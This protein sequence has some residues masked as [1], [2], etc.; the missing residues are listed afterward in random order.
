MN[1]S[2]FAHRNQPL[3]FLGVTLLMGFGVYSYFT[4]PAQEDPSITIRQAVITTRFPG[5]SAERVERLITKRLEEAVR[6]VPELEKVTST[7]MPGVSIIHAEVY[8][9]YFALDQ[10]WDDLRKKVEAARDDLPAGTGEPEIND[11][12]GDVAVVTVAFMAKDSPFSD[13]YDRAK[14]IR[15]ALYGVTGT[16]RV[17]VLGNR[18]ERIYVETSSA[19]LA[20]LGLSPEAIGHA[21]SLRNTLR[22]GGSLDT[23]RREF[24]V[25][26]SGN[27]QSLEEIG[28]TLVPVP[29]SSELIPVRDLAN[30]TRGYVDPPQR[31]AYLNGRPAIVFAVSMLEG[32]RVLDYC[33]AVLAKLEA[34]EQTLPVGYELEVIA[35]QSEQVANAVYGVTINVGQTLAI[36]LAVVLLFLGTRT[37]L[38]VGAIVPAVMLISLAIMGFFGIPLERMSLATLVIA[39][40][41]LVDNGIVIAEDFKRRL[42]EGQSRDDALREGGRQLALPLLS[43]TATT[44]LVFLPLMLAPHVSGEYTRS[45]SLVI[46]ISLLTSW[47]VAMLVTPVLR[48]RYLAEPNREG[49]VSPK[50]ELSNRIFALLNR[51]YESVLR[52]VL[53]HKTLF[54]GAM[55]A[56][57]AAAVVGM[58]FVPKKFFPD[59]DR[60]QV[61]IYVDLPAETSARATDQ[62]IREMTQSISD[63]ERFPYVEDVAGYAG[64]GG[65]RFVLS[66]TPS[67]P[68]PNQGFL[69]ATVESRDDIKRAI[70]ELHA[71]LI[72]EFPEAFSRVK[73]M[74][75]GPSDSRVIE[76]EVV[77]PDPDVL[78]SAAEDVKSMLKT[79]PKTV[80]VRSDWENRIAKFRVEVDEQRAQRAGLTSTDVASAL[81]RFFSGQVISEYREN[82]DAFPIV[83]R[84]VSG[85]RQN[86]Q[87]LRGAM[88]YSGITNTSVPLAQVADFLIQNEYSRIARK[89]LARTVTV[90]AR[91]L[92]TTAQDLVSILQP[93]LARLNASLPSGHH[94]QFTGVVAESAAGQ[95]ALGANFPLCLAIMVALLVAQFNSF[96]RP[97]IILLTIPLI[98]VGAALGLYVMQGNFGFMVMLG[99][100]SLAGIIVNNGIVLI[101]RIDIERAEGASTRDAIVSACVRRFRPIM[102]TTITTILGFLPLIVFQDV[103]FYEMA[104]AMAF[105]LLLGTILTLGVV[106]VLYAWLI[107]ESEQPVAT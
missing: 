77:G 71:A 50:A 4:L 83:S 9:R 66:L 6:Q 45:I 12:F 67:D 78:F 52:A 106:P 25:E 81:N 82:D 24:V 100:L 79:I 59:S 55:L 93:E 94:A 11:D 54:G 90:E 21:L 104:S 97:L 70:Q 26:P 72:Q 27:F 56:S 98:I 65:P 87:S 91:N 17:Q 10:I 60:D 92:E 48:H 80:D 42:E 76:V 84:A 73:G 62:L 2:E 51:Y 107:S 43:S 3:V 1:L 40:G 86:M 95:A 49:G 57:L 13:L 101:D 22:P 85:E 5:M 36:V 19:K 103:L 74:F 75:L 68:A 63:S 99:L 33:H 47:L 35:D 96:R 46:L 89:N 38:I 105:G 53:R 15:D 30:I 31:T 34:L 32:Y 88:V 37:G 18:E 39:L 29:D 20:E 23:G 69:V 44:V 7:S 64:F 102:M 16:K 28:A 14:H 58:V 41:L 61:L 8:D